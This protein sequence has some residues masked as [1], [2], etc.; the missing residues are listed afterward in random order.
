VHYQLSTS[1]VSALREYDLIADWYATRLE[2]GIGVPE[3]TSLAQSLPRGARVLDIGCGHGRPLTNVFLD[4]GCRVV[5]LDTAEKMIAHFRR[6]FP[7]VPV[8]HGRAQDACF[9]D[10]A[11]DAAHAWGMMFHLS[12]DDQVQ[13]LA[14]VARILKPGGPFLFTSGE[15]PEEDT[16]PFK[17]D[18]MNGV[19]FRYYS[20]T[21]A[22]YAD[23]MPRFG[24]TLISRH[25]DR[26]EN[27]YYLARKSGE[28]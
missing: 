9:A 22:Q 24:L 26:G 20:F 3:A 25:I 27:C 15:A 10:E 6:H 11:F 2:S 16:R 12:P 1:G 19:T 8:V 23:V 5:G 13:V 7:R 21:E 17:E 4:H 14:S 18:Q 28:G